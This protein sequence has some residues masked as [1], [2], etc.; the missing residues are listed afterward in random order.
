MHWKKSVTDGYPRN[1]AVYVDT[2]DFVRGF[3][4]GRFC[5]HFKPGIAK[6]AAE[7]VARRLAQ[8][9]DTTYLSPAAEKAI[10]AIAE[11]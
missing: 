7:V 8:A 3:P 6:R 2:R 4:C 11:S 1:L 5:H 9:G 10:A